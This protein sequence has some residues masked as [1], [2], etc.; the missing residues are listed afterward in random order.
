MV[1]VPSLLRQRLMLAAK[2]AAGT[3]IAGAAS[4]HLVTRKCYFEPFGLGN[5]KSLLE[6]PLL[7]QTNPWNKPVSH[8]SCVREVPFE[9]LDSALIQDARNGGM[10]LIERFVAG[11][12]GGF[13]YAIQRKIMTHFKNEANKNDVWDKDDLL[14]C[15]YEPGTFFTNHFLVLSKT[16][17]C[18]TMRGCFDP[19]QTPPAPTDIDNIVE[20]HAELDEVKKVVILKFRAL[21]F[22]G[23]QEASDKEDPFGGFGGWL[24][25]RYSSLLVESG[26]RNCLH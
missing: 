10:R 3:S 19:H 4:F 24:H 26:A 6:H 2:V 21:T 13:G 12:W 11:M 18:I 8:D 5:G 20:M 14:K 22:D 15:T 7:K 17:T 16:P 9:R 23:R 1:R 25:R